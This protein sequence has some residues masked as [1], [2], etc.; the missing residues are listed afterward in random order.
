MVSQPRPH[1]AVSLLPAPPSAISHTGHRQTRDLRQKLKRE[2]DK[3]RPS[4]TC[5]HVVEVVVVVVVVVVG[6]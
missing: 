4:I 5:R 2:G 6:V 3:G 1:S